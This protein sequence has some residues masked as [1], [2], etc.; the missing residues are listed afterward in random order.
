MRTLQNVAV[1]SDIL[2][3]VIVELGVHLIIRRL[4]VRA[5][6]LTVIDD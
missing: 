5:L 2:L 6:A 3:G 4:L 1:I